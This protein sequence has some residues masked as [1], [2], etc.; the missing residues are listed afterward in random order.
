MIYRLFKHFLTIFEDKKE[1]IFTSVNNY[2]FPVCR[3]KPFFRNVLS[4]NKNL[5]YFCSPL[6]ML[7]DENISFLKGIIKQN[8]DHK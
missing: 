2:M 1:I 7:K 8:I 5:R 4:K 3:F 6:R